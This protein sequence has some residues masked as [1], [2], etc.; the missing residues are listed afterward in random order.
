MPA[1]GY[2]RGELGIRRKKKR[3][4][5]KARWARRKAELEW[6]AAFARISASRQ[7]AIGAFAGGPL[8]HTILSCCQGV[9]LGM[10][11]TRAVLPLRATCRD[12]VAA[13]AA[14]PWDDLETVIRGNLGPAL[15]PRP[16]YSLWG[17][18]RGS[19]RACFPRARGANVGRGGPGGRKEYVWDADF[20]HLVGLRRLNMRECTAVTDAAFVHIA[21]IQS[22]D[23]GDCNRPT[24]TDAA[25][26]HLAGIQSLDMRGCDQATITDAAFSHLVGIQSLDM[27]GCTQDTIT[28]AAFVPL[29][30]ITTLTMNIHSFFRRAAA[31]SKV[32]AARAAGLPV[33]SE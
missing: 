28:D 26:V 5:R 2:R 22:L 11:S 29:A 21:G 30:G 7:G 19:W 25:F 32:A 1:Q 9:L 15:I 16:T 3:L 24:I 13:V 31:A 20:E 17:W 10:F 4:E 6:A 23:M 8:P 12:A 14:H 27:S 33:I 18:Q